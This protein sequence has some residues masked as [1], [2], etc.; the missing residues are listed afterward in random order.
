MVRV[1]TTFRK[2]HAKTLSLAKGFGGRA[3]SCFQIALPRLMKAWQYSYLSRKQRKRTM[4]A[5]FLHRMNTFIKN[6]TLS[7]QYSP[8]QFHL[9]NHSIALDRKVLMELSQTEP[10][11]LQSLLHSSLF[12]DTK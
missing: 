12:Y 3:S 10:L 2:K 11:T 9:Q 6:Q 8:F 4:R 7:L 1:K 5:L